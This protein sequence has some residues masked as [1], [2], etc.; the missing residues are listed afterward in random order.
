M[1][2]ILSKGPR[3]CQMYSSY[4]R[5]RM[6]A[7]LGRPYLTERHQ[8]I[9]TSARSGGKEDPKGT[10]PPIVPIETISVV[11]LIVILILVVILILILILLLIV[12]LIVSAIPI[13]IVIIIYIVMITVL[14]IAYPNSNTNSNSNTN[15]DSNSK[16]NSPRR[17]HQCSV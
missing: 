15:T 13:I 5:L 3:L 1:D 6:T 9:T 16:S 4:H 10:T 8:P 14:L 17:N 11:I 2:W 12:I 7:P